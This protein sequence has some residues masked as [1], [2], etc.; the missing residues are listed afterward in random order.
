MRT[1]RASFL[2][3]HK[4]RPSRVI[5]QHQAADLNTLK[6]YILNDPLQIVEQ[7]LVSDR[8][9]K[10]RQVDTRRPALI[11]LSKAYVVNYEDCTE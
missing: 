9:G 10:P 11:D 5:F 1:Y 7:L 4:D 3:Q 2:V 6:A 8:D